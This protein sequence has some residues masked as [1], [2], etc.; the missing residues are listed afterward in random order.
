MPTAPTDADILH[1][2]YA[3]KLKTLY[4]TLFLALVQ[5][6]DNPGPAKDAFVRGVVLARTV[7]D[8]AINALPADNTPA[9]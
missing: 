8:M 9:P 6:P 5:T 2:A 4:D 7:R 1:D 3:E